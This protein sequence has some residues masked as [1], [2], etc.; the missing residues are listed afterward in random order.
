[1][2]AESSNTAN[3][4][5]PRPDPSCR[6]ESKSS[7][8][9]SCSEATTVLEAPGKTALTDR[10]S[11]GPPPN[12][13]TRYRSGVP[14]GSSNT[15]SRRTSPQTVKTIVPGASWVPLALGQD[16]GHVG[17]RLD[18]VDQRR[19][20]LGRPGEQPLD[21]R[22]SHPRQ[23]R[24]PLDHLLQPG[25]LPEQIQIRA[26]DDLHRNA[27]ERVR[28]PHLPERPAQSLD[29][30]GER[31]L[32]AHVGTLGADRIGGNGQALQ[33]LVGVGPQQ[34]PVLEG[35]GLAFGG[36]A[37]HKPGA[38]P[39]PPDRPPLDGGREPRPSPAAEPASCYL[40]DH[41]NGPGGQGGLEPAPSPAAS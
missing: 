12:S 26:Q 39:D 2:H 33:D 23:R 3:P 27:A 41:G 32:Q 16:V 34:Q 6:I 13:S 24:T 38:G 18:V 22:A 5:A 1:M 15:P 35:G 25:L 14:R 19:V 21:E 4:A 30:R 36:V 10:P 31:L 7:G 9:S 40:L 37:D 11:G 17:Q 8:T 20:V 28:F 29:L